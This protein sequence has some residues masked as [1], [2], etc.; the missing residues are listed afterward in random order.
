V[1]AGRLSWPLVAATALFL[2]AAMIAR[3]RIE[4]VFHWPFPEPNRLIVTPRYSGDLGAL[5]FGSHRIAADVVLI[6]FLQYYGVHHHEA[7]EEAEK[8]HSLPHGEEYFPEVNTYAVRLLR[9]DPFFNSAILAFAG[10]LAFNQRETGQALDW[11][12]EAIERDPTFWRYRL[13]A[14]AILYKQK[15]DDKGLIRLLEEAARYPDCPG[16]L[17]H[18]LGNLFRKSGQLEK[19]ADIYILMITNS[20]NPDDA[21]TGEKSLASLAKSNPSV[22]PYIRN[23]LARAGVAGF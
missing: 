17:K 13:Y 16:V 8:E 22:A 3:I 15:G 4:S 18:V 5:L 14:A 20:R 12:K 21:S 1:R 6:Q 7:E 11:L 9:L 10:T 2:A 23:A 19:A